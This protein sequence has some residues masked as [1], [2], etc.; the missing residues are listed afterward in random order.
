[1]KM[2]FTALVCPHLEFGNVVWAP[3]FQKDRLLIEGVQRCATKLVPGLK[4]LDNSEKLKSMD[5]LPSMKY[6]RE[7]GDVIET[8][9]IISIFII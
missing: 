8:Y 9:K 5:N 3:C 6:R 4:E 1:M 2:L 7:R